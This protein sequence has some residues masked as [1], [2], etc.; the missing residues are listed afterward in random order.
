MKSFSAALIATFACRLVACLHLFESASD[1]PE[2]VPEKCRIALAQN[3]TC[4]FLVTAGRAVAGRSLNDQLASSYCSSSCGSSINSFQ[5]EVIADCGDE[6]YKL[7]ENSTLAQSGKTLADG[8]TW[9]HD[10]ICIEDDKGYCLTQLYSGNRTACSDCALKYGVKMVG[11]D[12]GR[13]KYSENEFKSVLSSCSVP[14]SSYP[15][16]IP[17]TTT[18][19]TTSKS[20]GTTTTT[21]ASSPTCGGE[22]YT[23]KKGDTCRSI[24]K[25]KSVAT[26]WL[27]KTNQLPYSCKS[28]KVGKSLCIQ[29]K[30]KLATIQMNQTCE[31][32]TRGNEI[33]LIQLQGWN[34][35][36]KSMCNTAIVPNLN[37]LEGRS[38]CIST[39]PMFTE[40][41]TGTVI[42][43]PTRGPVTMTDAWDPDFTPSPSIITINTTLDSAIAEYTQDCWITE[44]DVDN[45]FDVGD[46][47]EECQDLYD[48]YCIYH[49]DIAS[50]SRMKTAPASCTPERTWL[51][52][53]D[54]MSTTAKSTTTNQGNSTASSTASSTATKTTGIS[55]PSAIQTDMAKGC[56]KF[57]EVKSEDTCDKIIEA[58]DITLDDFYKWNPGVGKDCSSLWKDTYFCIAH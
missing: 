34:P 8:L 2:S 20:G 56:T 43:S 44:E 10:L 32:F 46:L 38:I 7:W 22:S 36:L 11:S 47:S 25:A 33:S 39:K 5:N 6:E 50:P 42:T 23:V 53:A 26:D 31:S 29:D 30:C 57:Y 40:W 51:T 21:Q 17:P 35:T 15:Y 28:I 24:S 49:S 54:S 14:S 27:I 9:A 13:E 48:D 37:N 16:T 3:I 41:E 19:E 52:T 55:T 1:I 12:F 18:A 45:F 58:N 4:D